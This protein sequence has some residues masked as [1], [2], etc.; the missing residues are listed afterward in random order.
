V[1]PVLVM[2]PVVLDFFAIAV[3]PFSIS[4]SVSFAELLRG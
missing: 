1:T 4:E 2:F 3:S